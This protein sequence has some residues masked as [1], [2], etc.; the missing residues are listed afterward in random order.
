MS[1]GQNSD[2]KT[3]YYTE[4]PLCLKRAPGNV[5]WEAGAFRENASGAASIALVATHMLQYLLFHPELLTQRDIEEMRHFL[6]Y[7]GGIS[8]IKKYAEGLSTAA[9]RTNTM[10]T[11]FSGIFREG[12][13]PS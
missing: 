7:V 11:R 6:T 8:G 1:E 3:S 5:R 2:E 13:A 12:G 9:R 10:G 4:V